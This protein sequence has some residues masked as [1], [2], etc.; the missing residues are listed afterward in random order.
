[1]SELIEFPD[2]VIVRYIDRLKSLSPAARKSIERPLESPLRRPF[3]IRAWSLVA[4][5]L[6]NHF[7][8]RV[9]WRAMIRS[10]TNSNDLAARVAYHQLFEH[11]KNNQWTLGGRANAA[12]GL[13]AL[14]N[15]NEK[16]KDSVA[17]YRL[18]QSVIP[19]SSIGWM[20]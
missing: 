16:P 5:Q 11:L 17:L 12:S 2:D 3:P 10:A 1:M 8:L 20:D 15:R 13:V 14:R 6:V 9:M 18:M 4:K 19:R 7:V